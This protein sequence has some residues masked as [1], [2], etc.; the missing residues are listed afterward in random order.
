MGRRSQRASLLRR[1]RWLNR[2]SKLESSRQERTRGALSHRIRTC[3]SP[4]RLF[5]IQ[6]L[7]ARQPHSHR[8]PHAP[9]W[10][11]TTPF[12]FAPGRSPLA[13][14]APPTCI[15]RQNP[16][17]QPVPSLGHGW[18]TR[19]RGRGQTARETALAELGCSEVCCAENQHGGHRHVEHRV[20]R[21]RRP[22]LRRVTSLS[23]HP[24]RLARSRSR[25]AC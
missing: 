4:R 1:H 21:G 13:D 10:A 15:V 2:N 5:Q 23:H 14:R 25:G 3:A 20:H 11:H 17:A 6:A 19:E 8:S 18:A 24:R 9:S 12:R 7:R 16:C 22:C